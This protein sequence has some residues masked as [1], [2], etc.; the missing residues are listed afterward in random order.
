MVRLH[1][2][3]RRTRRGNLGQIGVPVRDEARH[4]D[5]QRTARRLPRIVF[6]RVDD[7]VGGTADRRAPGSSAISDLSVREGAWVMAQS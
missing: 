3:G 7:S 2:C 1:D 6:E 5:E 4:S